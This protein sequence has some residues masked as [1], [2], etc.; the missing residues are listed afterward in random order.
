[1]WH[2][3]KSF[4]SFTKKYISAIR[5]SGKL[6]KHKHT[7]VWLLIRCQDDKFIKNIFS[8][9][10]PWVSGERE[11]KIFSV[12]E[13]WTFCIGKC[14]ILSGRELFRGTLFMRILLSLLSRRILFSLSRYIAMCKSW[15]RQNNFSRRFSK[16]EKFA[17]TTSLLCISFVRCCIFLIHSLNSST[18]F[19]LRRIINLYEFIQYL[20]VQIFIIV[21]QVVCTRSENAFRS[22]KIIFHSWTKRHR[23]KTNISGEWIEEKCRDREIAKK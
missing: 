4:L 19:F 14:S 7:C 12:D 13:L 16:T 21:T 3:V 22:G 11:R 2:D 23:R 15:K 9:S 10:P 6:F 17:K 1:M 8:F 20:N 18:L 5:R